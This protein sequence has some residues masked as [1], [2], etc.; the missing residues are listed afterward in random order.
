MKAKLWK[1]TRIFIPSQ[2]FVLSV[3]LKLH[4]PEF[5][6]VHDYR[7]DVDRRGIC[8]R[9]GS[10]KWRS[11]KVAMM[12][13][14]VGY[15][16]LLCSLCAI[17]SSF[18]Q[19]M[20]LLINSSHRP[21]TSCLTEDERGGGGGKWQRHSLPR[22]FLCASSLYSHFSAWV[23]LTSQSGDFLQNLRFP[24]PP[25]LCKVYL[26]PTLNPTRQTQCSTSLIGLRMTCQPLPS[27]HE[28]NQ[29]FFSN[30]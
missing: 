5:S 6:S 22:T 10:C 12:E 19:V 3:W 16:S 27:I 30:T 2:K 18:S 1:I 9:S 23:G 26:F 25:Q 24:H 8:M 7:L 20:N 4:F 15:Y 17:S 11:L 21:N 13:A 29:K 28:N 14:G